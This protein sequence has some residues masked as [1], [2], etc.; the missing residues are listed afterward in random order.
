MIG[1]N[2]YEY[3]FISSNI[4]KYNK[5]GVWKKRCGGTNMRR[6][7]IPAFFILVLL[8][9]SCAPTVT[10]LP[11]I[12]PSDPSPADNASDVPIDVTLSWACTDP[13]GDMLTYDIYFGTTNPPPLVKSDHANTSYN[14]GTLN[15]ETTYYWKIVAKDGKEGV[16]EGPVWSFTTQESPQHTLTVTTSPE[17]GL[18][19][20]IDGNSYTS[21]KSLEVEE[22]N[23]TIKVVTPQYKDKSTWVFGIDT[24]YKFDEWGDG[25][26]DNPRNVYIDRDVTYTANMVVSYYVDFEVE[27]ECGQNRWLLWIRSKHTSYGEFFEWIHI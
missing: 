8:I 6:I 2:D 11:P 17:T 9:W 19:V 5:F 16:T 4:I 15:Y 25:S 18:V 13:N 3:F 1:L 22:G 24:K 10:N 7:L 14:P 27:R 26:E 21:P 12:T 23:H 20:K